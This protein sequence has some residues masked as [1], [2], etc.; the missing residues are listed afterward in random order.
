MGDILVSRCAQDC[1]GSCHEFCLLL[2][3]LQNTAQ[4][5]EN[6]VSHSLSSV[7]TK[8]EIVSLVTLVLESLNS[9]ALRRAY[10][11]PNNSAQIVVTNSIG[12]ETGLLGYLL[13]NVFK[14]VHCC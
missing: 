5:F 10:A 2:V 13:K 1:T 4:A 12:K 7:E 8:E 6:L 9:I 14:P 3:N 11:F